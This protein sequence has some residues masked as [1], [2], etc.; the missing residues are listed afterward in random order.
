M[1]KFII[2][3]GKTIINITAYLW[4]FAILVFAI[5]AIFADNSEFNVTLTIWVSCIIA[6]ISFVVSYFLI[7]LLM[8]INDNL[9]EINIKTSFKP[10]SVNERQNENDIPD[11]I[12]KDNE[13]DNNFM[14]KGI[15]KK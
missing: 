8:D 10:E 4:L 11:K 3:S 7:Y 9:I 1:K 13:C 12:L 15:Y 14:N 2:K 6:L 5:G